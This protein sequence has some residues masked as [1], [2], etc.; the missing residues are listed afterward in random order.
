MELPSLLLSRSQC[1]LARD[2]AGRAARLGGIQGAATA[3]LGC[4]GSIVRIPPDSQDD[5]K[6]V[7]LSLQ[8]VEQSVVKAKQAMQDYSC[9]QGDIDG[10]AIFR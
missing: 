7:V 4:L 3:C 6:S 2:V 1:Q 8:Q 10:E 9:R 5:E